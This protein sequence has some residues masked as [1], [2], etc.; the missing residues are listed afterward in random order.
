MSTWW[1]KWKAFIS[2]PPRSSALTAMFGPR[3]PPFPR[4]QYHDFS[5]C[6]WW[7]WSHNIDDLMF[8]NM[9]RLIIFIVSWF[10]PICCIMGFDSFNLTCSPPC[11]PIFLDFIFCIVVMQVIC[12]PKSSP[13]LIIFHSNRNFL[14]EILLVSGFVGVKWI[15][16]EIFVVLIFTIYMIL[17][18]QCS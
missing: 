10:D 2:T 18:L 13:G 12:V 4:S 15:F 1:P 3:A 6:I 7:I 14:I 16:D 5:L 11:Y 8:V 9:S 17:F